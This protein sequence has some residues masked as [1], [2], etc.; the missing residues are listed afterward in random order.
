VLSWDLRF[1]SRVCSATVPGSVSR[2]EHPWPGLIPRLECPPEAQPSRVVRETRAPTPGVMIP[3]DPP[4][5]RSYRSP[6][7]P[8]GSDPAVQCGSC[9]LGQ[10]VTCP[11]TLS[12][13]GASGPCPLSAAPRASPVLAR[14]QPA[15]DAFAGTSETLLLMEPLQWAH[16]SPGVPTL[17]GFRPSS[18]GLENEGSRRRLAYSSFEPCGPTNVWPRA[19]RSVTGTPAT[20]FN[21]VPSTVRFRRLAPPV[22]SLKLLVRF[23]DRARFAGRPK[24]AMSLEY[25]S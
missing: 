7:P 21:V 15:R 12:R 20:L 8:S 24:S 4:A 6:R 9:P 10:P 3:R 1:P 11:G 18:N 16:L 2:S 25:Q 14:P 22:T 5:V 13:T 17:V 23:G 19:R